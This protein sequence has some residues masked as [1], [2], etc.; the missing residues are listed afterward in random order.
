MTLCYI[1]GRYPN[2]QAPCLEANFVLSASKSPTFS[3]NIF[4][5][6]L[7]SFLQSQPWYPAERMYK[8]RQQA[9]SKLI[10]P[11][12]KP[13]INPQNPLM[14]K[15][16]PLPPPS[17]TNKR[18][19]DLNQSHQPPHSPP[20]KQTSKCP[21]PHLLTNRTLRT[22]FIFLRRT[23]P[24]APIPPSLL[25]VI[26]GPRPR[27]GESFSIQSFPSPSRVLVAFKAW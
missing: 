14:P 9:T 19:L 10:T 17:Q 7:P 27:S 2:Y 4:I 1:S 23:Q 15:K 18:C 25:R 3:L 5:S 26:R 20:Q 21:R 24:L 12:S 13:Q 22:T 11:N 6:F 16:K 8:T